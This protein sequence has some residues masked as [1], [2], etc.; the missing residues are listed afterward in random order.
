MDHRRHLE[1]LK[2]EFNFAG[3]YLGEVEDVIDQGQ[4]V[5]ARGVDVVQVGNEG[6]IAKLFGLLRQHFAVADDGVHWRA[7]F[8]AH[9]GEKRALGAIGALGIIFGF[10][11]LIPHDTELFV[12]FVEL[13][14][15]VFQLG[16]MFLQPIFG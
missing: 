4:Q 8:M 6:I 13:I 2:V 5:A 14:G 9:I 10:F 7:Q 3:L 15:V 1:G 11:V 16:Y 12:H